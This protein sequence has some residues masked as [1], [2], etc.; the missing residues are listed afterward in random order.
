MTPATPE[1]I[2]EIRRG[3][4]YRSRK[5][6]AKIAHELLAALDARDASIVRHREDFSAACKKINRRETVIKAAR[7]AK[8]AMEVIRYEDSIAALFA[9]IKIHDEEE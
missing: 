2:E 3:F 8:L 5:E 4:P 1:R 6:L 7:K 9:A